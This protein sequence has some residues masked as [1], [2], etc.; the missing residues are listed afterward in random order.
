MSLFPANMQCNNG[1]EWNPNLGF[2]QNTKAK[3]SN[4]KIVKEAKAKK[5]ESKIKWTSSFHLFQTFNAFYVQPKHT[6]W[7]T[8][9]GNTGTVSLLYTQKYGKFFFVSSPVEAQ[10]RH[11]LATFD[12]LSV[13]VMSNEIRWCRWNRFLHNEVQLSINPAVTWAIYPD[14]PPFS[15]HHTATRIPFD[16]LL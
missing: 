7:P 10:L 5:V 2:S 1:I 9:G 8:A 3:R 14:K 6:A 15:C 11:L 13:A 12:W 4:E 16:L